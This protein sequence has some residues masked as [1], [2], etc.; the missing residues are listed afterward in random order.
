MRFKRTN[1][2]TTNM[3]EDIRLEPV[4]TSHIKLR[5]IPPE[6]RDRLIAIKDREGWRSW[7][8]MLMWVHSNR[9]DLHSITAPVFD[10]ESGYIVC[11]DIPLEIKYDLVRTK[12]RLGWKRWSD[13]VF[14]ILEHFETKEADK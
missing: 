8:E 13:L 11:R 2:L 12:R 10:S 3:A 5:G 6:I 1:T 9:H 14:P 7:A 4:S